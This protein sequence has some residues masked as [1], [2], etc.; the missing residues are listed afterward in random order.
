MPPS[1][2]CTATSCAPGPATPSPSTTS[3]RAAPA[4]GRAATDQ[5]T[6]QVNAAIARAANSDDATYVDIYTPFERDGADVTTFLAPDGDHPNAT[7]HALIARLLLRTT[8]GH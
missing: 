2:A 1:P 7:G 8:A 6:R 3:A 5:L 4:T